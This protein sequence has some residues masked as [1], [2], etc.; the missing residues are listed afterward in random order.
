MTFVY[1]LITG[2]VLLALTSGIIIYGSAWLVF[3][4]LLLIV[5]LTA[6]E[7]QGLLQ[8]KL[9]GSGVSFVVLLVILLLFSA[10]PATEMVTTQQTS[11]A[12]LVLAWFG[13]LSVQTAYYEWTKHKPMPA[14]SLLAFF[15]TP[16]LFC[17]CALFIHSISPI[18]ALLCLL[19][20]CAMDMGGYVAGKLVGGRNFFPRTSPNKT[21]A[22]L[23]GGVLFCYA[24]YGAMMLFLPAYF[25]P[26]LKTTVFYLA[27]LPFA[28][29]TQVGD[30]YQSMLKREARVKDSGAILPGHGG[31]FDRVD[32]LLFGVPLFYCLIIFLS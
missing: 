15:I 5:V 22:G 26:Q 16:F 9:F 27:L 24:V 6:M 28:L 18:L 31:F 29:L 10:G 3:C 20:I 14:A 11:F 8:I 19:M 23:M 30:L 17:V 1:R 25:A 7:W 21:Y 32:N 2:I 13:L 4:F 12:W